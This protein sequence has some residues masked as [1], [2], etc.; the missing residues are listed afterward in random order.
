MNIGIQSGR[1]F[2]LVNSKSKVDLLRK[3]LILIFGTTIDFKMNVLKIFP[4]Q[5][6]D[7]DGILT[8]KTDNSIMEFYYGTEELIDKFVMVDVKFSE[9]PS[10]DLKKL[11]AK[12]GWLLFDLDFEEYV[13]K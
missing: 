13:D 1:M 6:K 11:C 10:L 5:I 7:D 12:T 2:F 4:K 9:E 8:I 3:D